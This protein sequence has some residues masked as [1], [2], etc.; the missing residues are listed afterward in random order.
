MTLYE[1]LVTREE[2]E[3]LPDVR[4]VRRGARTIWRRGTSIER[5]NAATPTFWELTVAKPPSAACQTYPERLDVEP[6]TLRQ[7]HRRAFR[8]ALVP[9]AR[10][11]AL[12]NHCYARV[13]STGASRL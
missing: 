5:L 2:R 12:P 4:A 7:Q 6:R 13:N 8:C 10:R 3:L 9:R 1:R 11:R